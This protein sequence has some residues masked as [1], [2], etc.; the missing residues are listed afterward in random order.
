MVPG[1]TNALWGC[2]CIRSL[3]ANN[4]I[5]LKQN[6]ICSKAA[7][8]KTLGFN[9][10]AHCRFI[11][12][13]SFPSQVCKGYI[14]NCKSQGQHVIRIESSKLYKRKKQFQKAIKVGKPYNV[15]LSCNL[16]KVCFCRQAC[17]CSLLLLC[18]LQL[19]ENGNF[20]Y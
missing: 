11:R 19:L 6:Y 15:T 3:R 2:S 16:Q 10:I 17:G 13:R 9:I 20:K 1:V 14:I 12:H 4:N 5:S 7:Y 18:H 8:N